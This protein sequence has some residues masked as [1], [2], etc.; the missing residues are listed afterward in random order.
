MNGKERL[1]RGVGYRIETSA[2]NASTL[3]QS[4]AKWK[5]L[6]MLHHYTALVQLSMCAIVCKYHHIY[7]IIVPHCST[8]VTKW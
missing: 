1:Q 7:V 4:Q 5:P 3:Q 6:F 8:I 2:L